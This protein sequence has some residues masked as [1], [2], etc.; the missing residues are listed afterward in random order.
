M[1]LDD[2]IAQARERL[3]GLL[4]KRQEHTDA[5]VKMR[6][7]LEADSASVTDEQVKAAIAARDAFDPQIEQAKERVVEL[8]AEKARD[9]AADAL[10]RQIT[11]TPTVRAGVR[12]GDEP[13]VYRRGGEHSYFRDLWM[14]TSYGRRESADRLRRNDEQVAYAARAL[15]TTDGA[16]GEFVPP[17]WLVNEFEKLARPGRVIA[18]RVRNTP[19]PTG[20]DSI[21]LPRVT[22]GSS[23]AEQATQGTPLSETDMTS[24]SVTSAVAT[25]GGVQTVSLQLVEQSPINIDELVLGDL[26]DDY[27]QRI[28]LFVINN[29][30][31]N[32]RGLLNVTGVNAVTYTDATPTVPE[33][34]PKLVDAARQIHTARFKPAREVYMTPTRWAWFQA[35]LD[36]NNRPFVSDDIASAIPLLAQTDGAIPE[37]LAGKLRGLSLPIFLDPNIPANLGAG[38]NEDRIIVIRPEDVTLYEGSRKA[39]AFR[40][41]KAKEAQVVFRLYAYAAVMSERSP[42]SISV[43]SGTGLIQPTF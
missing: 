40:E 24:A 17:I 26:A 31:T 21:S 3:S 12:V 34:W 30:A 20:T 14:A 28:D 37:G 5:L 39:E 19:L 29:N 13:E 10:A 15:S 35:A 8:E 32:K 25:I 7:S 33:V 41:T 42:K 27:A 36:A 6:E 23:T 18:N 22:G 9:D 4:S 2:L 16:G 11:P 43:I 1:T 38:V